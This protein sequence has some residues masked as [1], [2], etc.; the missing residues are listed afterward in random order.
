MVHLP[1]T[2]TVDLTLNHQEREAW[3]VRQ[4]LMLH[5][6]RGEGTHHVLM[7]LL[8]WALFYHP[9]LGIEVAIGQHYKPDLVR[10][11]ETG[12]PVQWVDCGKITLTKLDKLTR[13]NRSALIDVVKPDA[14]TART[15][16]ES[17]SAKLAEPGRVRIW[18]FDAGFL[19]ALAERLHDRAAL[20]ATVSGATEHLLLDLE[21]ELLES[22]LVAFDGAGHRIHRR[23]GG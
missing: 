15:Y 11:D 3:G 6:R 14:W 4:R 17:A 5:K 21:G 2:L 16:A 20:V 12:E 8:A 13:K 9:A 19:D 1:T 23:R 10:L 7:K 22:D 18:G